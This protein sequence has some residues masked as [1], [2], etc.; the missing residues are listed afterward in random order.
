MDCMTQKPANTAIHES[1]DVFKPKH[2]PQED[3][4]SPVVESVKR[5]TDAI[6]DKV[7][8]K[9]AAIKADPDDLIDKFVKFAFP[10]AAGFVASKAF[11]AMWNRGPGAGAQAAKGLGRTAGKAAKGS[12]LSS[13]VFAALSAALGALVSGISERGSQSLVDRRHRHAAASKTK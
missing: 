9:R 4:P 6:N 5:T 1:Q 13:I 3:L 8:R 7:N 11:E 10:S 2:A 12:L